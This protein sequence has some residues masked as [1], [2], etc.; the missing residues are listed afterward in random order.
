MLYADALGLK[1]GR[2]VTLSEGGAEPPPTGPV[3]FAAARMKTAE[4]PTPVEPGQLTVRVEV[5][6]TY[7]LTR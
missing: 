6:A 4:A 7:E 5:S 1:L 3:V 2:L